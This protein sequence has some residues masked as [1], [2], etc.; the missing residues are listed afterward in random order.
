MKV[1]QMSQTIVFVAPRYGLEFVG[2]AEGIARA[3]AEA[4]HR[5]G[6]PVE[7]LTTCSNSLIMWDNFYEPGETRVNGVSVRRFPT[8]Q[9]DFALYDRLVK[10]V[11]AQP[12]ALSVAEQ[13]LMLDHSIHSQALYDYL[14]QNA[15]RYRCCVLTP[16]LFG[17]T[18]RAAQAIAGKAIHIPC[19]HDE[20]FAYLT[21]M[22]KLLNGAAGLLFNAPE[23]AQL[24][25]RL[26]VTNPNAQVVGCGFDP[27]APGDPLRF[28][29]QYGLGDTPFILYS[30]RYEPTKNVPLLLNHFLRY[31]REHNTPLKLVLIGQGPVPI[32]NHPDVLDLG[33]FRPGT[34]GDALA[35][36]SALVQISVNESFS[37][38][39]MEAW[40]QGRPVIV[41]RDC[42]VTRGHAERSAG[43]WVI[44]SYAEFAQVL[45]NLASVPDEADRRGTVGRAYVL[46]EY[47]WDQVLARFDVA[48]ERFLSPRPLYEQLVQRGHQRVREFSEDRF[49]ERMRMLLSQALPNHATVPAQSARLARMR[50]LAHVA[51][52]GYRVQ[53]GLPLLGRL[54]AWLRTQLTAHLKEPYLDPIV[55]Q[56]QQFNIVVQEQLAEISQRTWQGGQRP[57]VQQQRAQQA[58][59]AA[60]EARVAELERLL[61]EHAAASTGALG[62]EPAEVTRA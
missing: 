21:V 57:D 22:H 15:G 31:K 29:A 24:A 49:A 28:R 45:D 13:Q 56:Q 38:V 46:R 17:T 60:L 9:V 55:E 6:T 23:E 53:S 51:R 48:L 50:D 59:I 58:R 37:L 35:A 8:D 61:A 36:A 30:G 12:R 41:H 18:Y 62:T 19:L 20:P 52:P 43:G 11:F 47:G 16:Y 27:P 32:P 40:L 42:L 54:V 5:R 1:E 44:G 7:V 2:G 3:L 39:I 34:L 4:L 33:F 14:R 10:K 25:Q 26:G